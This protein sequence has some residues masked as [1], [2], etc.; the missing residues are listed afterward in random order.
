MDQPLNKHIFLYKSCFL[1][2]LLLLFLLLSVRSG[3]QQ[4]PSFSFYGMNHYL[5]NPAATGITDRVPVSASYR[6]IWLGFNHAP[7]V[8]YLS[9]N[10]LVSKDMGV[11]ARIS[12]Y[13]AGPLRKTGLEASY[14]YHLALGTG[15]TKL[16][17]GLSLLLYQFYLN[18]SDLLVK[19]IDD[20]VFFGQEQMFVPDAGFG[21]YLYA[22][23]Y[24]VGV[25]VP[26]LLQRN[27][28]LKSD[29]VL[30]EKQVRH[31][32]LHGGYIFKAG[33]DF[34]IEPS[35][36]LKLVEAG[37]FQADVNTTVTYKEMFS[38]GLSYR[39]G[40]AMSFQAGYHRPELFIGYAYDLVLSAM[41]GTSS[42]SHEILF[43]YVF[44][45]FLLK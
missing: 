39:T 2:A 8:Q 9:S 18:K 25:S 27:I 37:I 32:Y 21:I 24:Y 23:S 19:D 5:L 17:F 29:K 35:M 36:L 34:T 31:Y 43:T 12:N 13:Q 41:R 15:D 7:S 40:D 4:I 11:G 45:N 33:S 20:Q 30:Q 26:Q 10:M 3:A 28:D 22:P 6:E 38:L 1:P 16:S 42:G 14:S 44:D